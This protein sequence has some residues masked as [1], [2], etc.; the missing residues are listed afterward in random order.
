MQRSLFE[1]LG[2]DRPKRC[3]RRGDTEY[4]DDLEV[5]KAAEHLVCAHLILTGYRAFLSDQGLP[6]DILVDVGGNLLRVQV[7]ATRKPKNHDP[8]T[9]VSPGYLF[10]LRRAGKGGRRRYPANAFDLYALVAL[11]RQAI[12][13]LPACDCP[14]QTVAFRVPGQSYLQNGSLNREFSEASFRAALERLQLGGTRH[15]R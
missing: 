8:A 9:R 6:Y 7:K 11:D 13:Y 15:D 10:H 3:P 4:A 12:A 1:H 5:G 14:N 2:Y